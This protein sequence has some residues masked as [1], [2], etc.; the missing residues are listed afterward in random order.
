V[1]KYLQIS[2]IC[3]NAKSPINT[4]GQPY[5]AFS[6][7]QIGNLAHLYGPI[8]PKERNFLFLNYFFTIFQKYMSHFNFCKCLMIQCLGPIALWYGDWRCYSVPNTIPHGVCEG[9]VAP[10]TTCNH[11]VIWRL[12]YKKFIIF[13]ELGWR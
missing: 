6:V 4:K 8:Y 5:E 10:A 9:T 2:P 1:I 3:Q 11:R 13:Y 7:G 12:G